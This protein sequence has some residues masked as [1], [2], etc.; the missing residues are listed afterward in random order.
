MRG[1]TL[2]E[3]LVVVAIFGII[4]LI[5]VNSVILGNKAYWNEENSTEVMQNGRVVLDGISRE[6]RQSK[7]IISPLSESKDS[8]SD[9]IIFQDGHLPKI[10]ESGMSHGG[11]LNEIILDDFA[12]EEDD[13]YK[14]VFVKIIDDQSSINGEIRKITRYDGNLKEATID[15]PFSESENYFGLNYMIDSSYYYIHYYLDGSFLKRKAYAYYFSGDDSVYVPFNAIP[16]SE[17]SIGIDILEE[18]RIIGE[19]FQDI[20]FWG[21][22]LVNILLD[23][24]LRNHELVLYKKIFGRNL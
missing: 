22:N 10:V 20:S 3:I 24:K 23:L 18:S 5:V 17:E 21:T 14:G 6:I 19:H 11:S 2:I 13:F 4:F 16:P 12:S 15:Y 7:V 8:P 1:F 9:E